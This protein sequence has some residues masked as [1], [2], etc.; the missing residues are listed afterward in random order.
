MRVP[1]KQDLVRHL[2][3]ALARDLEVLRNAALASRE[4]A[5]HEEAKPENDKDTRA[6]EAAYLAGAQADRVRDLEATVNAL[7]FL[8][9][10]SFREGDPIALGA[11]VELDRDGERSHYLLAP[12]GGGLETT[13]EGLRVQV[14]TPRSPIGQALVGKRVGETIEL[15][16]QGGVR[17]YEIVGV[18]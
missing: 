18:R 16:R 1:A 7:G 3:A 10:R 12:R 11:L 5:T 4:A 15:R 13:F 8:E 6:I 17:E 9:L 2:G 14:V